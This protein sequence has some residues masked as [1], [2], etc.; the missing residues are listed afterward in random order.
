V[1]VSASFGSDVWEAK[2]YGQVVYAIKT[3][4]GQV[5][6]RLQRKYGD[7]TA[8]QACINVAWRFFDNHMLHSVL[9]IAKLSENHCGHPIYQ[10]ACLRLRRGLLRTI[11]VDV[12]EEQLTEAE[13][14]FRKERGGGN[15]G[16]GTKEVQEKRYIERREA[17]RKRRELFGDALALYKKGDLEEVRAQALQSLRNRWKLVSICDTSQ[18]HHHIS[19]NPDIAKYSR[20]SVPYRLSSDP[21]LYGAGSHRVRERAC[22]GASEL[23]RRRL[24]EDNAD[25]PSD[26]IQHCMLL[27]SHGPGATA[28]SC[29]LLTIF[30]PLSLLCECCNRVP[31]GC[32]AG[33]F[34]RG[35]RSR[36]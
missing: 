30:C 28:A 18:H 11:S 36:L 3:R 17:E 23:R 1:N 22:D 35:T 13:K 8:L 33:C 31:G 14:R 27:C 34:V 10:V 15:Y 12:Q 32:W 19:A 24:F 26:T 20:A 2:N 21:T 16:L 25:L 9:Q 29:P 6:L 4:N 5:Y 7:L